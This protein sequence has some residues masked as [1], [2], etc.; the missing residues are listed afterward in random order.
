[1]IPVR[2]SAGALA[3]V[4]SLAACSEASGPNVS[5]ID[6]IAIMRVEISPVL[7]TVFVGD[8]IGAAD[9]RQY[10]A[11]VIG[12][13]GAPMS[14]AQLAW[15]TSDAEVAAVSPSGVVTPRRPGR[16]RITA[17][18]GKAAEATLVVA[19]ATASLTVS[20]GAPRGVAGDTLR[21]EPQALDRDGLP[22]RGVRYGYASSNTATATVD[23]AGLVTLRAPGTVTITVTGAEQAQP[24]TITSLPRQFQA[25]AE[26]LTAGDDFTCGQIPLGRTYCWGRN[27][28]SQ[29]AASGDTTCFNDLES[30]SVACSLEALRVENDREFTKLSAGAAHSCGLDAGGQAWCWGRGGNG[31]IGNG[32]PG[33]ASEPTLVTSA[34]RF[35]DISAGGEHTCAVAV[36]GRVWCWGQDGDG[37]LGN[38][39]VGLRSTTPIPVDGNALYARVDAG[40]RHTC[41]VTAGGAIHC[42]GAIGGDV[43]TEVAAGPFADVQAGGGFSCGIM[44]DGRVFCW[45]AGENGQLGNGSLANSAGPVA[46][47]GTY[48]GI[49]VGGMHACAR[50]TAGA[51]SC[52]GSVELKPE[53]GHPHRLIGAAPTIVATSA[54]IAALAAG[55]RHTCG[56]AT[57]GDTMCWGSNLVGAFGDGLQTLYDPT[58]VTTVMP[59]RN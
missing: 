38:D 1:M 40:D 57:N 14:G 50:T 9:H 39:H 37:Q 42:W 19:Y 18:A 20:P 23:G 53:N 4:L 29:L 56:V 45:G 26:L 31:E 46:V 35:T 52:W 44:T 30:G 34:L 16:A 54:P 7:D 55:R 49:A 13:T 32:K 27:D 43:P 33:G 21:L 58:P 22:V 28:A 3:A 47:S 12:R 17:S 15:T 8:T 48:A 5:G 11:L 36:G 24:V 10:A 25:G 41:A 2:S 59:P 51:V 6:P